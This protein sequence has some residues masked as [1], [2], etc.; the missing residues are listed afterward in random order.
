MPNEEE[1][2]E[3]LKRLAGEIV[4]LEAEIGGS[5]D[6]LRGAVG[7]LATE[8]RERVRPEEVAKVHQ[9]VSEMRAFHEGLLL[10]WRR[11]IAD[12]LETR[13]LWAGRI[14]RGEAELVTRIEGKYSIYEDWHHLPTSEHW[15]KSTPR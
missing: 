11:Q 14:E 2:R 5:I 13:R 15:V 10:P 4:R 6:K 8:V 9:M 7:V 1:L 3:Q 12:E